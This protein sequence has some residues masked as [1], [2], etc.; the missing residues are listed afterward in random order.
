MKTTYIQVAN[1]SNAN[2]KRLVYPK[3]S[4]HFFRVQVV[5]VVTPVT[6]VTGAFQNFFA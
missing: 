5:T 4:T 6:L 2:G 1:E 3:Q